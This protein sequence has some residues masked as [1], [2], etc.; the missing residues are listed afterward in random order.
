MFSFWREQA[1]GFTVAFDEKE[2]LIDRN[3]LEHAREL[4]LRNARQSNPPVDDQQLQL[5]ESRENFNT[6]LQESNSHNNRY[7]NNRQQRTF[8]VKEIDDQIG[9]ILKK[10]LVASH[11][12]KT[13]DKSAAEKSIN[14]N[15]DRLRLQEKIE[16]LTE[17][18]S[19]LG[20]EEHSKHTNTGN[21]ETLTTDKTQVNM[22]RSNSR[23]KK[24]LIK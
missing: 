22:G 18:Y 5:R 6:S 19:I 15:V 12:L 16:T 10:L 1:I 4:L 17:Y 13:I 21:S 9:S 2:Q 23:G 7:R 24:K 3:I 14:S 20:E 11:P 8:N